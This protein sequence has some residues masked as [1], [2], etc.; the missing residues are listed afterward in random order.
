MS[1]Q[2][3]RIPDFTFEK[4]KIENLN[5]GN[6]K[7]ANFNQ[8]S[9]FDKD[10]KEQE[11]KENPESSKTRRISISRQEKNKT[12]Q[13]NARKLKILISHHSEMEIYQSCMDRNEGNIKKLMELNSSFDERQ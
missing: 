6:L 4:N 5:E 10:R 7:I 8:L 12:G 9:N 11:K 2:T 13:L 3:T 1:L